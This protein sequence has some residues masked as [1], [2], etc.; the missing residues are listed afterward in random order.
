MKALFDYIVIDN[1]PIGL[2]TDGIEAM[3]F[4]DFP[5]YVFRCNYSKKE[6]VQSYIHL[7]EKYQIKNLSAILNSVDLEKHMYGY[8][9]GYGYAYGYGY[10]ENYYTDS[11]KSKRR[12]K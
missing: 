7:K 6:F 2:V 11:R 4:A 3:K 10:G 1:A 8:N 9:Y 5:I 12:K